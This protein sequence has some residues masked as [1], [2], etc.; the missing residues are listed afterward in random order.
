MLPAESEGLLND[1][2]VAYQAHP[3]FVRESHPQATD[4]SAVL[5][6]P[7]EPSPTGAHDAL[8]ASTAAR[9]LDLA[10]LQSTEEKSAAAGGWSGAR[11][12][13]M[14]VP[15]RPPHV[16]PTCLQLPHACSRGSRS[17]LDRP[18]TFMRRGGAW[19]L[20]E[21]AAGMRGAGKQGLAEHA[22]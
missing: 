20:R 15:P 11:R 12:R 5:H 16:E 22:C 8:Q 17:G 3:G 10:A 2:W 13:V 19:L 1:S 7:L 18:I 4:R 14:Q 21:K 9:S 6:A